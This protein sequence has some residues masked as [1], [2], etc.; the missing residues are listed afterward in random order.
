M[1]SSLGTLYFNIQA[2]F[3]WAVYII[4]GLA[5]LWILIGLLKYLRSKSET[6]IQEAVHVIVNG[7]IILF[8][9]ISVW[10]LVGLLLETF[11]ISDDVLPSRQYIPVNS[12][13]K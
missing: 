8:V 9:M 12:L 4:I 2:L 6:D 11:G 5:V 1:R 3:N 13:I 7:I 10:A